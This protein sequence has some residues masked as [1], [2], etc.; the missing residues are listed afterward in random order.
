M[1]HRLTL[2]LVLILS[3]LLSACGGSGTATPPSGP[4]ESDIVVEAIDGLSDDFIRG[5]DVSSVLAQEASGVKYYNFDG[6]EQDLFQTLADAGVNYIRVRVWNDPYDAAGNGYGGGNN[7]VAAAAEIGARAAACGLKLLVDFHYSDFWADPSKQYAPKAWEGMELEE[8]CTA[9]AAFTQESLTTIREAGADIGMVQIGNEI[10]NG[11]AGETNWSNIAKLLEA[12]SGAVRAFAE[13]EALDVKIA[14]HFTNITDT[15]GFERLLQR[16]DTHAID[17]DVLAVSYYSFWHGTLEN[18]TDVLTQVVEQY[19]KEVMVAETSYPYTTEDGDG[20]GNSSSLATD[21]YGITVQGQANMIRDV[22]AAVASVGEKGI[23]LFYWEP[24]WIPVQVYDY[25]APDAAQ[26]LAQNQALWEQYGSGWA[27]SYSGEYDADAA[28]Y[29]GGSSWDNQ[30]LFDWYG[31]PL[32]SL[33]VFGLLGCGATAPK[34]ADYWADVA[35][36]V[37]IGSPLALPETIDVVFNDR[38]QEAVAVTWDADQTAAI[39]TSVN[40]EYEISGTL[41]TGEAVSAQ[42]SVLSVN[43]VTNPSFEDGLTG[44]TITG[45]TA[46]STDAQN[47][48]SDAHSGDISLHFWDTASQSFT[49]SQSFTDLEP[50]TYTLSC[51]LQGGDCGDGQ[52]FVLFAQQNDSEWTAEATVDGWINW[53]NPVIDSI[54]VTDGTLTIGM[55]VTAGGG[56]WGTIDDFTLTKN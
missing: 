28:A 14:V 9:L 26:V 25:T 31:H 7:D 5:V 43:F 2:I 10:N 32:A 49:V 3:L 21:G 42:V 15:T 23:G 46:G 40:G 35:L 44:W 36:N 6:E 17:Y 41:S 56:G 51:F 29:Y 30:A 34:Q 24:A 47:K 27:S 33:K 12:A 53:K 39:D 20:H 11:M 52:S 22:A 37:N 19:G 54:E 13:A 50:G 48:S 1:K 45:T 55:E 8:K 18:L 16:L 38:S 4:V